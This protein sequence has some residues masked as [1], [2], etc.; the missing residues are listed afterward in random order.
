MKTF[1]RVKFHEGF[2]KALMDKEFS[3]LRMYCEEWL[4]KIDESDSTILC[5]IVTTTDIRIGKPK[6]VLD[7]E[8]ALFDYFFNVTCEED[9]QERDKLWKLVDNNITRQAIKI[10]TI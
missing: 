10:I 6:K 4:S 7:I 5:E 8:L 3:N 1:A 9:Q 2:M